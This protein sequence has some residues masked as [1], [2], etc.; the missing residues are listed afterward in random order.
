MTLE[1]PNT[2]TG[3]HPGMYISISNKLFFG[4]I[5]HFCSNRYKMINWLCQDWNTS[6]SRMME[7]KQLELNQFSDG[8]NFLGVIPRCRLPPW[9]QWDQLTVCLWWHWQGLDSWFHSYQSIWCG[10]CLSGPG[11][12]RHSTNMLVSRQKVHEWWPSSIAGSLENVCGSP[13]RY[14]LYIFFQELAHNSSTKLWGRG[15]DKYKGEAPFC[16]FSVWEPRFGGFTWGSEA[17]LVLLETSQR[18]R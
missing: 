16:N 15:P 14:V 17:R 5:A 2:N 13:A 1:G 7:V 4:Y 8:L 10:Q 6:S 9:G 12:L 11:H 3:P 18:P